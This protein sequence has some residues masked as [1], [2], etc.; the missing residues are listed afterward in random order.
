MLDL[1]A[2]SAAAAD[3]SGGDVQQSVAQFLGFGAGEGWVVV[4]QHGLGPGDEV[5]R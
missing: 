4:Q 2:E 5:D 3:E 1:E